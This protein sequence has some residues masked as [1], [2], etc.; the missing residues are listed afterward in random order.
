MWYPNRGVSTMEAVFFYALMSPTIE[1]EFFMGS[2]QSAYKR[3][4]FTRQFS[5]GQLQVVIDQ[6]SG[7]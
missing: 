5:S 7:S 3:S 4:E 1:R 2:V 6:K